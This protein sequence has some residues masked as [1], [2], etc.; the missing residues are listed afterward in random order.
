MGGV[1]VD[2]MV[3]YAVQHSSPGEEETRRDQPGCLAPLPS[4]REP[5]AVATFLPPRL[6]NPTHLQVT[7][8]AEDSR[9]PTHV[10]IYCSNCLFLPGEWIR[11][12]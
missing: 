9:Q 5:P 10:C 6:T 1:R 11:L 12:F 3:E 7:L 4:C 8:P 2:W